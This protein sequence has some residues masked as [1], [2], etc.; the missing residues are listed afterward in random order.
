L[1][2]KCHQEFTKENQ[3]HEQYR[4]VIQTGIIKNTVYVIH[5][6]G[7]DGVSLI[8]KSIGKNRDF[9]INVTV[10]RL[11]TQEKQEGRP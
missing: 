1:E 2:E 8:W 3:D 10:K 5:V 6:I 9:I 7:G 11:G 4:L